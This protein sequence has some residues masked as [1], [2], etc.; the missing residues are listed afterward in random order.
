MSLDPTV[1]SKKALGT[2][3]DLYGNNV[4]FAMSNDGSGIFGAVLGDS[5]QPA[6]VKSNADGTLS[7][8]RRGLGM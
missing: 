2:L 1:H 4:Q 7:V 6:E 5:R 3:S 8:Q